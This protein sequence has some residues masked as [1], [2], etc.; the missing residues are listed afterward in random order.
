MFDEAEKIGSV[1][2]NRAKAA[3]VTLD[4]ADFINKVGG[5]G[6]L[7]AIGGSIYNE[8]MGESFT[9]IFSSE[10]KYHDRILGAMYPYA[11]NKDYSNG[12]YFWNTTAQKNDPDPGFNWNAYNNGVFKI[13]TTSSMSTFFKFADPNQKYN[14]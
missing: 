5:A 4:D 8:I 10:N 13:T 3:N 11:L 1:I 12:A 7:Q 6:Q 2:L 14:P 9:E